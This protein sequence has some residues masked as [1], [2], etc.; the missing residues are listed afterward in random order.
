MSSNASSNTSSNTSSNVLPNIRPTTSPAWLH[1]ACGKHALTLRLADR[2]GSRLRGLMFTRLLA[3]DTGL[4]IRH[5]N[6]V[7]TCFMRYAIDVVYLDHDG[8]VTR[9]VER[10]RPWRASMARGVWPGR[11]PRSCH[12]L[13]LPAGSIALWRIAP[14]DRLEHVY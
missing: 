6:S 9:C 14:R 4:L 7:H 5:C 1:T 10:L 11:V 13:E 2:F 3:P 12:V 8:F